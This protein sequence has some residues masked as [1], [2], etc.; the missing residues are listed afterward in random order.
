[1]QCIQSQTFFLFVSCVF[2]TH[3]TAPTHKEGDDDVAS[4]GAA[5]EPGGTSC[6]SPTAPSCVCRIVIRGKE[7]HTQT[8]T[9]NK[10]QRHTAHKLSFFINEM[11]SV[12]VV[13][14]QTPG[15]RRRY[16]HTAPLDSLEGALAVYKRGSKIRPSCVYEVDRDTLA[17]TLVKSF[18]KNQHMT[19]YFDKQVVPRMNAEGASVLDD[20]ATPI[21]DEDT[22]GAGP[23]AVSED[24]GS[25]PSVDGAASNAR[26]QAAD[27]PPR[28][29][30]QQ[31]PNTNP[32]K[33]ANFSVVRKIA[34]IAL[35][36][37]MK[38]W[39]VDVDA[40]HFLNHEDDSAAR[41]DEGMSGTAWCHKSNSIAFRKGMNV[42]VL[43]A[44]STT[45]DPDTQEQRVT[46]LPVSVTSRT[47]SAGYSEADEWEV[48]GS[49]NE[50]GS[51]ATS[52]G[53]NA[54]EKAGGQSA[55][56]EH[57]ET[58]WAPGR[59][60]KII[61]GNGGLDPL[62][63]EVLV[64]NPANLSGSK[65]GASAGG[66]SA[67]AH[68]T[69]PDVATNVPSGSQKIGKDI[70]TDAAEQ[71]KS[72]LIKDV[73]STAIRPRA[74]RFKPEA[75]KELL[76]KQGLDFPL[77]VVSGSVGRIRVFA[78]WKNLL[79]GQWKVH[80]EDVQIVVK[81]TED[82]DGANLRAGASRMDSDTI[83]GGRPHGAGSVAHGHGVG[84]GGKDGALKKA[85]MLEEEEAAAQAVLDVE[86]DSKRRREKNWFK[87]W[88]D[89][90]V[91]Q[92]KDNVLGASKCA[93]L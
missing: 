14:F 6:L 23:E 63:C 61:R 2:R 58:L 72:I 90:K 9:P 38:R 29:Q 74:V 4:N 46:Y 11:S 12:W 93:H 36:R 31:Q 48:G 65:A 66:V 77:A 83:G 81:L 44:R 91:Q 60:I 18:R 43:L 39:F 5:E 10:A 80:L 45:A 86:A 7:I 32:F 62:I 57:G 92:V 49:E 13:V 28:S 56:S 87:R 33:R 8:H 71:Q 78:P 41:G 27:V 84:S 22:F 89:S 73:P 20:E 52:R 51:T 19:D 40:S 76:Q 47:R 75:L 64:K 25:T 85:A 54:S 24:C 79:S 82:S 3:H 34:E 69:Q 15:P 88:L 16:A 53:I 37:L 26:D 50:P 21:A 55:T 42:D 30:A 68:E 1:M 35:N 17:Y 70:G 59:I 67:G